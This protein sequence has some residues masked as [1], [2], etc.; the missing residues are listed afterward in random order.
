[1]IE[2][3]DENNTVKQE[4][5]NST[6]ETSIIKKYKKKYNRIIKKYKKKYNEIKNDYQKRAKIC[7]KLGAL[8]FQRVVFKVE[9]KKYTLLKKI[10]PNF[11]QHYEKFSDKI[12]KRKLKKYHSDYTKKE[13][14]ENYRLNKVLLREEFNRKQN[15]NYHIDEEIPTS[16]V[17]YLEWNKKIHKEGAKINLIAIAILGVATL[18]GIP[19]TIP[20]LAMEVGSLFI[21]FQCINLQNYNIY[22]IKSKEEKLKKIENSKLNRNSIKYEEIGKVISKSY[23]KEKIPTAEDILNNLNTKEELNQLK[24]LLIREINY[25]NSETRVDKKGGYKKC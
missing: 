18:I 4:N 2:T 6:K 19:S 16:M 23:E 21:N 7:E 24:S 13:I 11:V 3:I 14:I 17:H 22:R 20:F 8:N 25:R 10:C 12:I 15:R 5:I 9:I 1:M